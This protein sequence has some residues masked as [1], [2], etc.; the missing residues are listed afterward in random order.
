MNYDDWKTDCGPIPSGEDSPA[1]REPARPRGRYTTRVCGCCDRPDGMCACRVVADTTPG[2]S[3]DALRCGTCRR[4]AWP[5]GSVEHPALHYLDFV[6]G[7]VERT[8][9]DT[10]DGWERARWSELRDAARSLRARV[11]NLALADTTP[12]D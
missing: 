11:R 4:I 7:A 8:F 12:E 1:E 3:P 6:V 5:D 10:T 2:A 9:L